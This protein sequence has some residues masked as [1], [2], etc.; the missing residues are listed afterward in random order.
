MEKDNRVIRKN[1]VEFIKNHPADKY[2]IGVYEQK[3]SLIREIREE[4]DNYF[5]PE[6]KMI[7]LDEILKNTQQQVREH[8]LSV[9]C[10]LIK[11]KS[12]C[13]GCDAW[14][15]IIF[16]VEQEIKKLPK[17]VTKTRMESVLNVRDKVF[18]SYSHLDSVFLE[19]LKRH[20]APFQGKIEFWDDHKIRPGQKWKQEIS[21]ALNRAKVGIL[22][23]S[24]DFFNSTF[25]TENELPPLLEAAENDGATILSVILKPCMFNE[26][27]QLSQFQA[28][29]SPDFSIIQMDEAKRELT[30]VE[31][32]KQI[33]SIMAL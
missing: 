4:I 33:K 11:G 14:D 12:E 18:I 30:W 17:I 27:P 8:K 23:I 5:A 20:F 9:D 25:I 7:F 3:N 26:Y 16:F 24:A 21:E 15:S 1:A 22:L 19:Q 2:D 32:L 6:S 13:Y 29:N 31:L 28:I 10:E